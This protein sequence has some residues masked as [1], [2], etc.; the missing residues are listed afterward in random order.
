MHGVEHEARRQ[1]IWNR[2]AKVFCLAG[3]IAI[4]VFA[5]VG[6]TRKDVFQDFAMARFRCACAAE[7]QI[8]PLNARKRRQ[9]F[10]AMSGHPV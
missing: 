8:F 3:C 2:I 10:K 7:A 6:S 1:T 4:H 5:N 9:G